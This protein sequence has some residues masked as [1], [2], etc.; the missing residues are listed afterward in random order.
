MRLILNTYNWDTT[1]EEGIHIVQGL[2][3]LKVYKVF[4]HFE[5]PYACVLT[6]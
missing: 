4:T 3:G 2:E 6:G 5:L 1:G